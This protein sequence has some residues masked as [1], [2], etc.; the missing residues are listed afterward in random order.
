MEEKNYD[1]FTLEIAFEKESK[2]PERIFQS[3]FQL[4]ESCNSL[5]LDLLLSFPFKIE[6]TFI[7]SNIETGSLKTR[8]RDVLLAID[9]N[10]IRTLNWR[11]IIGTFLL[12]A[13]HLILAVLN[14]SEKVIEP[15]KIKELQEGIFNYA[16][17]TGLMMTP[18]YAKLGP[19]QLYKNLKRFNESVFYLEEKD[20]ASLVSR[21]GS[22]VIAYNRTLAETDI[23]DLINVTSKE[24]VSEMILQ[25]KKPDFLGVSQWDFMFGSKII[26]A[27]IKDEEWLAKFQARQVQI[28]P[29]DAIRA[30][31][32]YEM[33]YDL[34]QNLVDD[35]YEIVKVIAEIKQISFRK[36]QLPLLDH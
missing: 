27:K 21:Q 33:F 32:K 5:N 16:V 34:D 31:V 1:E 26:S 6:S 10:D 9:D 14:E 23:S 36:R 30:R 12:K 22:T 25:I 2:N 3:M 7:L 35:R 18:S 24:I 8:I 28:L 4:I 20:K 13:K 17:D 29:G 11:N 15:S 19:P